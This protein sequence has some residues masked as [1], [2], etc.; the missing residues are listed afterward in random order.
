MLM[1]TRDSSIIEQLEAVGRERALSTAESASLDRAI[2]RS[3]RKGQKPWLP[4]HDLLL[5]KLLRKR[6]RV[7]GIAE[8]LGRSERSVWWRIRKLR[9]KGRVG[10]IS[11]PGGTG[12]Y[13]RKS[14][15]ADEGAEGVS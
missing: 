8:Q 10:Y 12:R 5:L 1:Q 7:P 15:K 6:N 2:R 13:P 14:S 9:E 11:P 4:K 3:Q